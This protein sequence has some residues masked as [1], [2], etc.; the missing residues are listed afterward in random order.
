MQ[1][2][3]EKPK[4]YST[5]NHKNPGKNNELAGRNNEH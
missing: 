2:H 3:A 5:R 1:H 4:D